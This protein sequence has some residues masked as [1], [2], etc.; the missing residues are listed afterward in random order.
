MG[1]W[2]AEEGPT[3]L[4]LA[5]AAGD[6]TVGSASEATPPVR[7]EQKESFVPQVLLVVLAGT[8]I[9]V[10]WWHWPE[11]RVAFLPQSQADLVGTRQLAVL[12]LA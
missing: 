9:S 6:S 4:I 10:D 3:N 2:G 5:A 7:S 11:T 12:G 1:Q 8:T